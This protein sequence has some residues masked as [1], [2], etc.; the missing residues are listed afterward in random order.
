M[1]VKLK[2]HKWRRLPKPMQKETGWWIPRNPPDYYQSIGPYDSA[3]E[4]EE[5]RQGLERTINTLS[6]KL[7]IACG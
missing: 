3:K 7:I 2:K 5:A 6:W 1:P 4:A